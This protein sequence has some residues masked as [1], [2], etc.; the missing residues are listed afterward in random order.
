MF[1][2]FGLGAAQSV[3]DA[4]V[5]ARCLASLLLPRLCSVTRL[6]GCPGRLGCRKRATGGRSRRESVAGQRVDLRL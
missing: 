4:A 3:E 6:C 5:L 2:F 1:P